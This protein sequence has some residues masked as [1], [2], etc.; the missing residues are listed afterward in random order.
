MSISLSPETPRSME[1]RM[2]RD[3]YSS[4][5]EVVRAALPSLERERDRDGGLVIDPDTRGALQQADG[6]IE[7]GEY[8]GPKEVASELRAKYRRR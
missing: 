3:G 7:R 1:E 8:R 2:L 4:A 6:E 5:D